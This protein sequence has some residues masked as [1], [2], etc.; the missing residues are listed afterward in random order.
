MTPS[1]ANSATYSAIGSEPS[2]PSAVRFSDS[3]KI[4]SACA[5]GSSLVCSS[6]GLPSARL[7]TLSASGVLP[8]GSAFTESSSYPMKVLSELS[9]G[10]HPAAGVRNAQGRR[11]G[12]RAVDLTVLDHFA[13]CL[14][15]GVFTDEAW[16]KNVSRITRQSSHPAV[17]A[18]GCATFIVEAHSPT[19]CRDRPACP[20]P[21]AGT[22][23]GAGPLPGLRNPNYLGSLGLNPIE[24]DLKPPTVNE[25]LND[26]F[27]IVGQSRGKSLQ[28]AVNR[29]LHSLG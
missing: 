19:V 11:S 6:G 24:L 29:Q 27:A 15:V 20:S 7:A 25:R 18:D 1:P 5:S 3:C 21:K 23:A 22:G 14:A 2:A 4:A 17:R 10:L 8:I 12:A 9:I 28:R 13:E 16:L 26:D